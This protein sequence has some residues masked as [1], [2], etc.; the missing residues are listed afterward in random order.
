MAT[1]NHL[2]LV[3][4]PLPGT[5]SVATDLKLRLGQSQQYALLSL[6]DCQDSYLP[7]ARPQAPPL[8]VQVSPLHVRH[9]RW[10]DRVDG[11]KCA[12]AH[13]GC[14]HD[15]LKCFRPSAVPSAVRA[16]CATCCT[17]WIWHAQRPWCGPP[18]STTRPWGWT[19]VARGWE[20]GRGSGANQQRRRKQLAPTSMLLCGVWL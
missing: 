12:G 1:V 17:Q 10:C 6:T 4:Q 20:E 15:L 5:F 2:P 7:S 11:I 8:G 14:L 13:T 3:T 19:G 16:R 9:A 18:W